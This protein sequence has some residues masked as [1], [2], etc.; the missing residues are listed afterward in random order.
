MGVLYKA[1]TMS[2]Q[3]NILGNL[4]WTKKPVYLSSNQTFV[5]ICWTWT[6]SVMPSSHCTVFRVVRSLLFSHCTTIWGSIQLLLCAY[7]WWIGDTL[8]DLPIIRIA[9]N[10]VSLSVWLAKYVSQPNSVGL[11]YI[12]KYW[13]DSNLTRGGFSQR[14]RHGLV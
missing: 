9:D 3:N 10:S 5:L 1:I 6:C 12:W 4:K 2:F 7:W 11:Y 14:E 13:G 8:H